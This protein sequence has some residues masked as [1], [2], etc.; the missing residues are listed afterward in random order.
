MRDLDSSRTPMWSFGHTNLGDRWIPVALPP[1]HLTRSRPC[2][3][4]VCAAIAVK[5]TLQ[6]KVCSFFCHHQYASVDVARHKIR[7]RGRI[8]HTKVLNAED[9]ELRIENGRRS[10]HST[11]PAGM[12]RRN[13][14][15][16][17][18]C[19]N[20]RIRGNGTSGCQLLTAKW[21]HRGMVR[22]L[23]RSLKALTQ[24]DDIVLCREQIATNAH[25]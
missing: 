2:R 11:S 10:G 5:F 4:Q 7:H 9:T 3:E 22:Q 23:S 20:L 15:I 6:D 8:D 16:P 25:R 17:D 12:V 18:P 1:R 24:G 21:L 13:R 14:D 19:V